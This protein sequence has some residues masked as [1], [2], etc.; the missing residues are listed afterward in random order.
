MASDLPDRK[1]STREGGIWLRRALLLVG[2]LF[3]FRLIY[4]AVVPIDLVHDEA[5][6]WDWSRQLDWGY[7]S[8][9]PMVAWL[10]ALSTSLGGSSAFFVRLPA[11]FLSTGG[12]LMMY[13]LGSRIYGPKAGFWATLLSVATP[14]NA[15]LGLL[16]TIDAPLLFCW[17]TT[18]YCC[19]RF[20]ERKP[21]RMLWLLLGTVA[22]GLGVLSKQTMMGFIPLAGVFLL[23]S[24]EDRR[25]FLRPGVWIWAIGSLLFLAP[26]LWWNSQHGWITAQHTSSHFAGQSVGLLKRLTRSGEFMATQFGVVSPV[27]CALFAAV[28]FLSLRAF[29]KLGRRERFLL[30]F[31]A[32]PMI[33][34]LCLSLTQ[35]VEPNWPAAF[36]PAGV[37]LLVGWALQKAE[38]LSPLRN[39]KLALRRAVTVGA[40][41]AGVTYILPFGLGLEGTKL[42]PVIRLRG[43]EQ[44]G[45]EVGTEFAKMPR[46]KETFVIVA[47]GRAET[48]ELAFYMPQRPPIYLW[49]SVGDIRSQYDVWGGPQGK[50]NWDA[51]I[52]TGD[53]GEPP[54]ALLAAFDNVELESTICV[55]IGPDLRHCYRLWHG[56]G[57]RHWPDPQRQVPAT[58]RTGNPQ[59]MY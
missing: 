41:F 21:D 6:Y 59:R 29:R 20:L 42:D 16:M 7:Y 35:R 38:G 18:L 3:V 4:A 36:Y 14:G 46:S 9:P 33:G 58:A 52:V 37:L 45:E 57:F 24:R 1:A 34:V 28:G 27:T 49:N 12:L 40:A 26:V 8:K 11:I 2:G 47:I 56:T 10:I 54:D 23:T 17:C 44:L 25:E 22:T 39:G 43:W 30:C 31:S 5:Y 48:S 32:L 50:E 51:M 15:A 53:D 13:A 19:W 55:P